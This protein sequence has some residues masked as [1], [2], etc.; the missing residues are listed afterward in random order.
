LEI[1]TLETNGKAEEIDQGLPGDFARGN[2]GKKKETKSAYL[3]N[4][5]TQKKL[6]VFLKLKMK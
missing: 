5:N 6:S 4:S 3:N 1:F 2:N